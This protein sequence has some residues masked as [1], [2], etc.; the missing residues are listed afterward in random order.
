M[1]FAFYVLS[2][3]TRCKIDTL[4]DVIFSPKVYKQNFLPFE[5]VP[6]LQQDDVIYIIV[7]PLSLNYVDSQYW[8]RMM[9][10]HQHPQCQGKF[11]WCYW[12]G[13]FCKFSQKINFMNLGPPWPICSGSLL[14]FER[15]S[16]KRNTIKEEGLECLPTCES[17]SET[18]AMLRVLVKYDLKE[19]MGN[20]LFALCKCVPPV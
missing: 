14:I 18:H 8:F 4:D 17:S 6:T 19:Q 1:M 10:C 7:Y 16:W 2:V 9:S 12:G 5:Q 15:R 13:N 20:L 11:C 3:C